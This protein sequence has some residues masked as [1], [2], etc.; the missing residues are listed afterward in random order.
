MVLRAGSGTADTSTSLDP[1]TTY[2]ITHYYFLDHLCIIAAAGTRGFEKG[3]AGIAATIF[4]LRRRYKLFQDEGIDVDIT[5]LSDF[6]SELNRDVQELESKHD[7]I[8][9]EHFDEVNV[10][11]ES[12]Q[13]DDIVKDFTT[14]Q[15]D[16]RKLINEL[17]FI[18]VSKEIEESLTVL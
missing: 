1:I 7:H 10:D 2:F 9:R 13:F 18:F 16:T 3:M 17:E 11:M 12:K 5:H 6:H 15:R 14:L 4:S 8:I